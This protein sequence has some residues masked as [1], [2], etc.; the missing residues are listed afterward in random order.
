MGAADVLQR[1]M[2]IA[3]E[4]PALDTETPPP[5]PNLTGRPLTVDVIAH[6]AE[7]GTFQR[8]TIVELTGGK[9]AYWIRYVE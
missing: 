9:P 8:S 6:D 7:G 4:R 3:G 1:Q 5:P 2:E